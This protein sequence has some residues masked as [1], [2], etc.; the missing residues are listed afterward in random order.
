M[1]EKMWGKKNLPPEELDELRL[2]RK[3]FSQLTY[4]FK[5]DI[6]LAEIYYKRRL[7]SVLLP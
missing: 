7:A 5:D 3:A 2:K 1:R 6:K 4:N